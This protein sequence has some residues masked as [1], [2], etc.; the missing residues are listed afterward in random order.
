MD[1]MK[2]SKGLSITGIPTSLWMMMD[3][4]IST[5]DVPTRHQYG[6]WN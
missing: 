6:E 2:K 4:Y 5:G 1:H 3:V